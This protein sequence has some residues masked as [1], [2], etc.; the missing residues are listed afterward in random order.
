MG[1]AATVWSQ[2][3]SAERTAGIE[4]FGFGHAG[5]GSRRQHGES[6]AGVGNFCS[7]LTK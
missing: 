5:A 1:L 4:D 3:S 6:T 2:R 7:E